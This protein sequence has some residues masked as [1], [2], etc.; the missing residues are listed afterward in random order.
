MLRPVEELAPIADALVS[1]VPILAAGLA[2]ALVAATR[3]WVAQAIDPKY[4]PALLP[5]AGGLV[6]LAA[7]ALGLDIGDVNAETADLD[8]WQTTVAG[9]ITG[10][11]TVGLHQIAKQL[12]PRGSP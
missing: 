11:F 8:W 4:F 1:M 5:I 9:V 7:K 12:H 3:K 2:S 10:G 6:A